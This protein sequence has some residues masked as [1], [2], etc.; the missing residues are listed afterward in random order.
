MGMAGRGSYDGPGSSGFSAGQVG[1][2]AWCGSA[3]DIGETF[4]GVDFGVGPA[5]VRWPAPPVPDGVTTAQFALRRIIDQP[6]VSVVIPG[7]RN[8]E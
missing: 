7:A 4:S 5:A 8:P 2:R 1:R 6:G 3:F